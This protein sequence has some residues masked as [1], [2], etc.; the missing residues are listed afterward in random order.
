MM[1]GFVIAVVLGIRSLRRREG[2]GAAFQVL[3]ARPRLGDPPRSRVLV[4]ADLI[5]TITS[6]QIPRGCDILLNAIVL[7]DAV[8]AKKR[9][10]HGLIKIL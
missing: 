5:R 9:L 1:V 10:T 6:K 4:A 7:I 3:R 2:G 8:D